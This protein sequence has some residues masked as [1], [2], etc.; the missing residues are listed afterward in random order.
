[1]RPMGNVVLDDAG[2]AGRARRV[3]QPVGLGEIHDRM[4]CVEH[5]P[6]EEGERLVDFRVGLA[7]KGL[8]HR[9]HGDLRG[10]FAVVVPPH[11]VGDDHHQRVARV[12][13]GQTILVVFALALP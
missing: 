5:R 12:T 2:N 9:L 11:A 4:V 3:V 6:V 13:V 7:L 10:N 8:G 1:M